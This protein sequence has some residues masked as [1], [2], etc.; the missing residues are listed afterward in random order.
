MVAL[1]EDEAEWRFGGDAYVGGRTVVVSGEPVDDLFAA[2]QSVNDR[3][4]TFDNQAE[5]SS[6]FDGFDG[7]AAAGD[8]QRRH[9]LGT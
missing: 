5:F 8:H 9:R 2:G 6:G 1:A 3:D 7:A 4:D